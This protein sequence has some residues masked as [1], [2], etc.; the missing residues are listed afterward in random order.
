MARK[1]AIPQDIR[2]QVIEIVNQFNE[3]NVQSREPGPMQRLMQM[4]G[5]V[6]TSEGDQPRP[7]E[8]VARFRGSFLYLD[9][10]GFNGRLSEICRLKWT[11][12]MEGWEFA[13]YRHSKNRYDPNEWFFPGA[14]EVD[15]TVAGAMKAGMAAY[16]E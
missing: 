3:E 14:G 7:G 8:Y 13:I 16:P 15:G 10:V 6:S 1:K 11:G 5:M 4:M 2:D 9:R 12:N